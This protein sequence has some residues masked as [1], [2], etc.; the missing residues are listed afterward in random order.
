MSCCLIPSY[1]TSKW[2]ISLSDYR[3]FTHVNNIHRPQTLEPSG[4]FGWSVLPFTAW[5]CAYVLH[6]IHNCTFTV[7]LYSMF[8]H[9]TSRQKLEK[10][11]WEQSGKRQKREIKPY[12]QSFQP[13]KWT[14]RETD[15]DS[16]TA[17]WCDQQRSGNPSAVISTARWKKSTFFWG[18]LVSIIY[19]YTFGSFSRF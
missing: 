4:L 6:R 9:M 14:D 16:V 11:G 12:W 3:K 13:H 7:A 2:V 17:L 1:L 5:V 19:I 10:A 15:E 8:I 18:Q